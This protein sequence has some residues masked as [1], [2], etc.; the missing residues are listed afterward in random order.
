M[1]DGG[2][3]GL[4]KRAV[5]IEQFVVWAYL[6]QRVG[7]VARMPDREEAYQGERSSSGC[8][9]NAVDK[10]RELGGWVDEQGETGFA[11]SGDA[12]A[13]E[14]QVARLGGEPARLVRHYGGGGARPGGWDGPEVVARPAHGEPEVIR[15]NASR[16][17]CWEYCPVEYLDRR[18]ERATARDRWFMW[19]SGL[20]TLASIFRA[21]PHLLGAHEVT[22]FALPMEPWEMPEQITGI[23]LRRTR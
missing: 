15:F 18:A 11:V 9:M 6:R 4:V 1:M 10:W 13:L 16:N 22:G 19:W 7:V 3:K 8:G 2:G 14:H 17:R 5:D 23:D 21:S 20:S 12:W